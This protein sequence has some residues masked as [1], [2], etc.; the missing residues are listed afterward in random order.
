LDLRGTKL[1]VLSA[2][3]TGVSDVDS[4]NGVHG[5]RRALAVAG[6]ESQVISLWRVN[7]EATRDVMVKFYSALRAGKGRG[8]ALRAAKLAVLKSN[9]LAHPYFWAGFIQFGDWKSLGER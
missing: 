2:C 8:E 4:G 5:L 3:E 1:V 9:G 7:D 6:A